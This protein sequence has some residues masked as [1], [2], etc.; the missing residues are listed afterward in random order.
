MANSDPRLPSARG[1]I[2]DLGRVPRQGY[3]DRER[4]RERHAAKMAAQAEGV[5]V[6]EG[7]RRLRP[8]PALKPESE[9]M[10]R[11]V[12]FLVTEALGTAMVE[13][14]YQERLSLSEWVRKTVIVALATAGE[15]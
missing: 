2:R 6:D 12:T 13:R 1:L 4:A 14:A 7:R 11:P 15:G 8:G 3:A 9:R 5:T 10:D